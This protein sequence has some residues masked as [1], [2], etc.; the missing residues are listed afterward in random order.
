MAP[1]WCSAASSVDDVVGAAR[2]WRRDQQ[3][4]STQR[5]PRR[6]QYPPVVT[7]GLTTPLP[8]VGPEVGVIGNLVKTESFT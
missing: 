8:S 7:C 4:L 2:Q 5:G 3:R 6:V 1:D